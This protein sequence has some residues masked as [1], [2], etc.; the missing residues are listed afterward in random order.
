MGATS[1]MRIQALL[2]GSSCLF[3]GKKHSM[4]PISPSHP[5]WKVVLGQYLF[6]LANVAAAALDLSQQMGPH[7]KDL[8][9]PGH[10]MSAID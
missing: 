10:P 2:P 9:L 3:T 8:Y 5:Q 6:C 1:G 4:F 7:C